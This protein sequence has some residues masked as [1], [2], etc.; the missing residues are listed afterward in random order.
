MSRYT[1]NPK[2]DPNRDRNRRLAIGAIAFGAII[3][4]ALALLIFGIT[5]LAGT[6]NQSTEPTPFVPEITI[7]A[8]SGQVPQGESPE[9]QQPDSGAQAS[10]GMDANPPEGG[11][12]APAAP[13]A[14]ADVPAVPMDPRGM[15][16]G[17]DDFVCPDPRPAPNTFGYG[18]QSNWPVGDI[19]QF[20]SIMAEQLNMDWT[21]AQVRWIDFE[22]E[23]G[24]DELYKWQLLDAFTAD[25]NRK[26]LNI[27]FGVLDAPAWTRSVNESGLLGPPDDNNEARR[28]FQKV[29][30]RYKGCVQ[31]IE[32]WNEMNLDREWTI[33]TRRIQAADYV[34]FLDAV[35][36]AIR[37]IDPSI[38]VLMGALS[39]TGA[40]ITEGN[41][42]KVVDDLTYLDQFVSAGGPQRVD[43][44]G[45]HLNGYNM[46]PD[47]RHDEGFN[48]PTARFRGP[49]DSPHPSWSFRSTLEAYHQKTNMPICATEFGW[50]S[51][52]NLKRK[53]GTSTQGAPSGFDFALDNTEQE[54]ADWIVR[55]FELM[56]DSGYVK[57]AIVFNLDYI[58]KVGGE[59]DQE[60]VSPYSITRRD[61][62]PRPAFNAIKDM[63]R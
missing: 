17:L 43:C 9:G 6:G 13:A 7:F 24:K 54:Q 46:P 21:K 1:F 32:V 52:E 37:E 39:P 18:I 47:K 41:V 19:G 14:A 57:F 49:F 51:M 12:A 29:A 15:V 22:P 58:Q 38:V 34:Q 63:P 8:P 11:V 45:I 61:G 40:N 48:D 23:R 28:F 30:A 33:P 16:A 36:P 50:A 53:D 27:L 42:T 55:A 59:P 4:L 35:V 62:S 25:A 56:R 10:S 26:G 60:N 44:I 20:N 3:L 31:A 2:L 5:Q